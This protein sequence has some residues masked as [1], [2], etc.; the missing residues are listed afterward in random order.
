MHTN[1]F[2]SWVLYTH[3][4]HHN[5][6]KQLIDTKTAEGYSQ[7]IKYGIIYT[8][9]VSWNVKIDWKIVITFLVL[10]IKLK[11]LPE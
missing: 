10:L 9:A 11:I 5:D 1:E 4:Y 7:Q 6:I 2:P 8:Q 3:D